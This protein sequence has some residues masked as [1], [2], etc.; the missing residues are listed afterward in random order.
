MVEELHVW[1]NCEKTTETRRSLYFMY[2]KWQLKDHCIY[3][4]Q[5]KRKEK[6]EKR[7]K[8]EKRL[9]NWIRKDDWRITV[10]NCIWEDHWRMTVFNCGRK[11][12]VIYLVFYAHCSYIRVSV[13]K[14][15]WRIIVLEKA[16]EGTLFLI[17]FWKD[18]WRIIVYNCIRK[19][20]RSLYVNAWER[21]LEDLCT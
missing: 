2:Q 8:K 15:H 16:A 19:T 12:I 10:F 7:K 6:K 3:L 5:K 4:Y 11:V 18:G 20:A 21:H 14:D 17:V 1:H 9:R 13:R